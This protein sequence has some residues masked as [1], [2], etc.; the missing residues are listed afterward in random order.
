MKPASKIEGQRFSRLTVIKR[1][2][3]NQ[4]GNT[5]WL[6]ACDCGNE[7]TVTQVNLRRGDI[8]SC[9][10]LL[11]EVVKTASRTHGWSHT[12]VY[13]TWIRMHKRCYKT[14]CKDYHRYG[15]RG[16]EVC[17]RW[18]EFENFLADMGDR[19][20]AK[21]S[22]ERLDNDGNYDPS[23]C[24]WATRKEQGR[25]TCRVRKVLVGDQRVPISQAC[26]ILGITPGTVYQRI[27][28]GATPEEALGL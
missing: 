3:P 13:E 27:H 5:R 23:N 25:N 6:C 11:K 24:C 21:H 22:I 19:P 10:C 28:R 8:R 18:H 4:R 1:V 12:P 16:I 9:G 14:S 7:T 17:Q 20:S 2:W 26:E 15:G